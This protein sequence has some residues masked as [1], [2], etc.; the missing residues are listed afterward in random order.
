MAQLKKGDVIQILRKGYYVC[1]VPFDAQTK[2]PCRLLNI[3]DGTTKEKPTALKTTNTATAA[4][5]SATTAASGP[6]V[7]QLV[8]KITQQGDV[9]RQIKS[10]KSAP[11]VRER[12]DSK[13]DSLILFDLGRGH[14]RR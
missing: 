4:A 2:Q 8:Q 3:P 14:G 13:G 1:D 12:R 10:N 11:K 5:P 6:D 9:V 7:D